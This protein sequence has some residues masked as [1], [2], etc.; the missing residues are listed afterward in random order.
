MKRNLVIAIALV[1]AGTMFPVASVSARQPLEG[2]MDLQFNLGW[3]GPQ[4]VIPDWVGTV[5]IEGD[6]Y[7]MAFFLLG[8][9]K[10]FAEGRGK[11]SF[12]GEKW[13]IY[14]SL[15]F[16]FDEEGYLTLFDAGAVLLWGYDTGVTIAANSKYHMTGSV[17]HAAG[18]FS[19]WA[20][21]GVFM[22]GVIAWYPS[23]WPQYAPGALRLH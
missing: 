5:T 15:E 20:G 17:E 11:A 7:G 4:D 23:G 12:F 18:P 1:L 16:E 10:P 8:S 14:E 19:E 9:G 13:V 3:P 6:Q 21:R 2:T 22:S